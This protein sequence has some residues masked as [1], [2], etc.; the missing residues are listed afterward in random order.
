VRTRGGVRQ[1]CIIGQQVPAV[2]ETIQRG[3]E[4]ILFIER[5]HVNDIQNTPFMHGGS[6]QA[7]TATSLV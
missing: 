2:P 7:M 3:D 1:V 4:G 6:V 5:K